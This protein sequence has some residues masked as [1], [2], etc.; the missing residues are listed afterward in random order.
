MAGSTSNAQGSYVNNGTSG[1][2][3]AP[4]LTL[5]RSRVRQPQFYWFLGHFLTLYHFVRFHLSFWSYESQRHHYSMVLLYISITYA[6]VLYQFYK[7]GQL[8]IFEYKS[9]LKQVK[10]LDNLQYFLILSVLFV[11]SSFGTMINGSLYSPVIFSLFHC[12]NYFKENLLPFLALNSVLKNVVNNNITSFISNYNSNFLQMA[13]FFEIICCLRVGLLS[14]PINFLK[15]TVLFRFNSRTISN[16]IACSCYICFFKLRFL[17]S[18]ST[19]L[20]LNQ[21]LIK[22]EALI[23]LQFHQQWHLF[24]NLVVTMFAKVPVV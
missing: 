3:Q 7:S 4:F 23:P 21:S 16:I 6:I 17:Q 24:K 9:L 11:C 10:S 1:R 18:Q 14:L 15:L 12:L 13:Q 19:K 2:P 22:I 20:L 8:K 5:L